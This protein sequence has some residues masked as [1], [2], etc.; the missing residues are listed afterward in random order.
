MPLAAVP[1]AT[2]GR[3]T[4]RRAWLVP[5]LGLALVALAAFGGAFYWLVVRYEPVATRHVLPG[6]AFV[7]RA[8]FSALVGY[9][10]IRRPLAALWLD[11][12]PAEGGASTFG[13][14]LE[15]TTGI[16]LGRDPREVVLSIEPVGVAARWVLAIGGNFPRAVVPDLAKLAAEEPTL[17]SALAADGITLV[18]GR[19]GIAIGQADDRTLLIAS[20]ATALSDARAEGD[21]AIVRAL[22]VAPVS[23]AGNDG[24]W[25]GALAGADAA[26]GW[27][28]LG[29]APALT[30]RLH[31]GHGVPPPVLRGTLLAAVGAAAAVAALVHLPDLAGEQ[32]ALAGATVVSDDARGLVTLSAPWPASGLERG[33]AALAELVRSVRAGRPVRRLELPR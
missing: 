7:V 22:P 1:P 27:L 12:G 5:V 25:G 10:P 21:A 31:A 15:D 14:R 3:P 17:G 30:V 13:D 29:D 4:R 26:N 16:H 2:G 24:V 11:P 23:F 6:A 33:A 19:S 18:L 20:D 8:D 28:E 9:A 32:Q